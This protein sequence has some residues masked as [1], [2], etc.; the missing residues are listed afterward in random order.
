MIHKTTCSYC[1]ALQEQKVSA[2]CYRCL[3]VD[4]IMIV[5]KSNG[6]L[7]DELKKIFAETIVSQLIISV[8][9]DIENKITSSKII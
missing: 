3:A 2:R 8:Y 5:A 9:E 7:S 1:E 4:G 6:V